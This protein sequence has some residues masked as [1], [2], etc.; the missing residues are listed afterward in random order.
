[1]DDDLHHAARLKWCD[2][3]VIARPSQHKGREYVCSC[4]WDAEVEAM[5]SKAAATITRLVKER[6]EAREGLDRLEAAYG[7]LSD[8]VF[9]AHPKIAAMAKEL[10]EAEAARDAALE[11]LRPFAGAAAR[12]DENDTCDRV[13]DDEPVG[14]WYGVDL[15]VTAGHFRAA[16]RAIGG[17]E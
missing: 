5:L 7:I 13:P 4:G 12:Y 3:P 15:T 11:A 2:K 9:G 14:D 1:M 17:G 8:D 6:D 16:S 10:S